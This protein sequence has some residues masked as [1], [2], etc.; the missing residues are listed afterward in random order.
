MHSLF[1]IHILPKLLT[2]PQNIVYNKVIIIVL[3]E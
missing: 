2:K 3:G 1:F